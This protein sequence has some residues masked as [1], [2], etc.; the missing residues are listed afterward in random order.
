VPELVTLVGDIAPQVSPDGTVSVRLTVPVKPFTAVIV[1]VE[2]AETPTVTATGDVEVIVK[3]V[4]V[5][6]A[7]TVW[8]SVPLVPVIV[9]E[10]VPSVVEL[11]ETV[12]V[13]EVVML[14]GL[15]APHVRPERMVSV[16]LTVPVNPLTAAIVIVEVAEVP[17]VTAAGEVAVMLKSVTVNVPVVERDRV[18]LVPVIVR[19]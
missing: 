14:V 8:V 7:V 5:K 18:P 17:T 19:V 13:P 16:R 3:S 15:M 2:V 4:T 1:I 6:I 11:Q 9:S 10:Y 12:A